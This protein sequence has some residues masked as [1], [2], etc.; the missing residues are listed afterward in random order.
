MS[1][2]LDKL[3]S[4]QQPRGTFLNLGSSTA[5]ECVAIA[6]MDYFILDLEHSPFGFTESADCIRAAQ[7]KGISPLVRIPEI[8]RANILKNL[9]LGAEG[10]VIP[11]LR[12]R[13]E[14]EKIVEFGRYYPMGGRGFCP[15]RTCDFGYGDAFANG[16]LSYAEKCNKDV[17]LIP[18]CETVECL[19]DIESIVSVEGISGIFI[20]PFDLSLAMGIPTQFTHPD[21]VAAIERVRDVCHAAGKPVFIFTPNAET[22]R[23]RLQ[24]GFDSVTVNGNLNVMTEAYMQILSQI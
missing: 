11:G 6:G 7:L 23:L 15:T 16:V 1:K 3:Q 19:A 14:A 2:L 20:G 8:S 18:Q 22:A 13:E 24:Q 5:A 12:T 10:I 21:F 4:G 17:L 9:D